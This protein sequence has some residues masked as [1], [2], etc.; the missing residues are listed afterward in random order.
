MRGF[1][2]QRFLW[3]QKDCDSDEAREVRAENMIRFGKI[4]DTDEET[5]VIE[6]IIEAGLEICIESNRFGA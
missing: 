3:M 4:D 6:A 1:L 2:L 5:E